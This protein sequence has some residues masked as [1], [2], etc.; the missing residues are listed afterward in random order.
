MI[1][2]RLGFVSE[3]LEYPPELTHKN[4]NKK[5][6]LEGYLGLILVYSSNS[7]FF[8]TSERQPS[9]FG[10]ATVACEVSSGLTVFRV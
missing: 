10:K 1:G 9:E 3:I 7:T 2:L 5:G 8:G 4:P 6:L